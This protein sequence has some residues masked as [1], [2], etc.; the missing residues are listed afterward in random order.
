MLPILLDNSKNL[1]DK[2][3]NLVG[4]KKKSKTNMNTF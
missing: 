4:A 2:K 3:K 1:A